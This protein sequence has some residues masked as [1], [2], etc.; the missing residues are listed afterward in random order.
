MKSLGANVAITEKV[1]FETNDG[2]Q[3]ASFS[4][5]HDHEQF[6]S[7]K[8]ALCTIVMGEG[9]GSLGRISW[10]DAERVVYR[11]MRAHDQLG[12]LLNHQVIHDFA[13]KPE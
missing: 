1:V 10:G 9:A 4:E 3:F 8:T 7:I 2:R 5:A 13:K 11:L 12:E 6:Q